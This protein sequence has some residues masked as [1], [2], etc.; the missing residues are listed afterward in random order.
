MLRQWRELNFDSAP[1]RRAVLGFAA[2]R[3]RLRALGGGLALLLLGTAA[4]TLRA[5]TAVAKRYLIEVWQS[6]RGLPQNT[7]TGI[8]Q[9]PDGYLW[10]STLDGLARFDGVRFKLFKAG[11][12]PALGSG[13]I[14]FLFTGRQGE[15]WFATQEGGVIRFKDGRFTAVPLPESQGTRPAVIQ[16]A[17]DDSGGV[18]LSTEDGKVGRLADGRYSVVSTNWDPTGKTAFQVRAD[19]RGRLLAASSTG[20]YEVTVERL[21][22]TLQGKRG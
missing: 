1:E 14:R 9:T 2:R 15:L 4:A 22:P 8:A 6:E 11:N 18:W 5:E 21:A 12:T 7:V 19:V 3:A 20:L 10:I 13:R 16:V 17:E